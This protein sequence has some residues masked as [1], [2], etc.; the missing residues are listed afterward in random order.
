MKRWLRG[1]APRRLSV[2]EA[3]AR[4]APGY[5]AEAHNPLMRLEQA[6]MVELLPSAAGARALD[7]A[8]GSGRYLRAL[9]ERG[10]AAIGLDLSPEML[11]RAAAL[12]RPLARGEM[13]RLPFAA[14]VFDL[15]V[16]GL[17]VGHAPR[18]G[19]M[20]A[21][22]ARVLRAG[23]AMLYSDFHPLAALSGLE[24]TFRAADG[25][26]YAVE[27][28]LHLYEDHHAACAAAGLSIAAVREPRLDVDH[29]WR[30]RPAAL[31]ILARKP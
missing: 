18:L 29:P 21:E 7:L 31:V 10:A 25:R 28:H 22:A 6:A 8:C 16:C 23:G 26:Q 15:V 12:G 17:A 13:A 19:P 24:R 1:S 14:A 5:A 2:R 20:L 4:W 30:G 9:T 11:G 27:H 3:Y